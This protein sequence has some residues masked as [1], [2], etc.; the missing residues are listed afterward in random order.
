[1]RAI[2]TL[3]LLWLLSSTIIQA[4]EYPYTPFSTIHN[5][6]NDIPLYKLQV[7]Y[8]KIYKKRF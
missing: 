2:I 8:L 4:Q 6:P 7:I 5:M 3:F 1:M